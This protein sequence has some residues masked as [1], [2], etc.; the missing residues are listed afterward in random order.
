VIIPYRLTLSES[1]HPLNVSPKRTESTVLCRCIDLMERSLVNYE[2]CSTWVL[3]PLV[4]WRISFSSFWPVPSSP[5]SMLLTKVYYCQY[6]HER[7]VKLLMGTVEKYSEGGS[8]TAW[9]CGGRQSLG[10]FLC[11]FSFVSAA[12]CKAGRGRTAVTIS[13]KISCQ[14]KVLSLEATFLLVL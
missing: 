1:L 8:L 5:N 11:C 2:D 13:D 3:S 6:S 9:R 7:M 12:G 10:R 4:C 14:W